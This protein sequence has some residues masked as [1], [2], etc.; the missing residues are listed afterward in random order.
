[1]KELLRKKYSFPIRFLT[2]ETFRIHFE[3]ATLRELLEM[4]DV[5]KDH[6]SLNTWLFKFLSKNARG[7]GKITMKLYGQL[8]V[9][10]V[11]SII[12]YLMETY[13]KGYFEKAEEGKEP[14]PAK[15][16]SSSFIAFLLSNSNETVDS[17]LGMTW[18]Q[19]EYLLEG[20]AWNVREQ[21]K[22]GRAENKRLWIK[23]QSEKA[24]S[25][26]EALELIRKMEKRLP[27]VKFKQ[28]AKRRV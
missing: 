25:D 17:L 18:E 20:V 13:A 8:T 11:N 7:N 12:E 6:D 23:K 3:Q 10:H 28:N 27:N 15:A 9:K 22:D 4:S 2:K 5:V 14:K 21:S 19:I 1:M 16:P 26:K 24:I